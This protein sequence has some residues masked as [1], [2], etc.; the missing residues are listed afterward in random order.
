MNFGFHTKTNNSCKISMSLI[1][2]GHIYP[3]KLIIVDMKFIHWAFY[4]FKSLATLLLWNL[5]WYWGQ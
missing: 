4:N 5:L 3:R 2:R 1:V